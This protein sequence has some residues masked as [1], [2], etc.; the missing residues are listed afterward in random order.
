MT[1]AETETREP[2]VREDAHPR[3][4]AALSDGFFWHTHDDGAPLGSETGADT[5]AA[6]RDFRAERPGEGPLVLLSELLQR[7]EIADAAWDAVNLGDVVEAGAEDEYSLLARD[8]V[9]L[10]LA[11]SQLVDE[12]RVDEEVRRRAVLA[13]TRQAL[14]PLLLPWGDKA[15][16]RAT[17]LERMKQVLSRPW[18]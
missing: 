16:E 15:L 4:A 9:I 11:F 12:G 1:D 3:A 13:T 5:L 18:P 6:F 17:R 14:P 7:W 10:A 8:E 2:L